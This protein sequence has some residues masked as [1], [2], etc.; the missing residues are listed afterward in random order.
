MIAKGFIWVSE[1]VATVSPLF[2]NQLKTIGICV[3]SED[4]QRQALV[5][6]MPGTT[7]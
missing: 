3:D 2:H 7:E 1:I 4:E 5:G 6:G